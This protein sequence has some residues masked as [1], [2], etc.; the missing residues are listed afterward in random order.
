MQIETFAA[1]HY[2]NTT[3]SVSF[4]NSHGWILNNS[5][6]TIQ[7]GNAQAQGSSGN[8]YI[9]I[10]STNHEILGFLTHL[11]KNGQH[12]TSLNRQHDQQ[13]QWLWQ[14]EAWIL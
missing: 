7:S 13:G 1:S 8:V 5:T 4:V 9:Q 3:G 11:K 14:A 10:E 2:S 12:S 6:L